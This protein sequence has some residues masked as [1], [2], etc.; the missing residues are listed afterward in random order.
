M[1]KVIGFEREIFEVSESGD[2]PVPVRLVRLGDATGSV[3]AMVRLSSGTKSGRA[4]KAIDYDDVSDIPV[5]WADGDIEPKEI[6]IPVISDFNYVEGIERLNLSL[7]N[8]TGGAVRGG[9]RTSVVAIKNIPSPAI[10]TVTRQNNTVDLVGSTAGKYDPG[11]GIDIV[12]ATSIDFPKTITRITVKKEDT[13][14]VWATDSVERPLGVCY[15]QVD[16][17]NGEYVPDGELINNSADG[18]ISFDVSVNE[19]F[20][21]ILDTED[22]A[23]GATEN[24]IVAIECSNLVDSKLVLHDVLVANTR[25]DTE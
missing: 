4:T 15:P 6:A 21:L 20:L 9:I 25:I 5:S 8:L 22:A 10:A 19:V 2:S 12:L 7:N 24:L 1:T 17:E 18:T 13:G 14:D 23:V 11:D 3:S 16:L